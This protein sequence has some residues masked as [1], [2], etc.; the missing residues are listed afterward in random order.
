MR[1]SYTSCDHTLIKGVKDLFKKLYHR[2]MLIRLIGI[3]FSHLVHGNYQINLFEDSIAMINLYKAIDKVNNR[4]GIGAI[5]R[6]GSINKSE[7]SLPIDKGEN[8]A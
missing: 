6:A 1:I 3:K 7:K 8:N 2:R 4:F 5:K